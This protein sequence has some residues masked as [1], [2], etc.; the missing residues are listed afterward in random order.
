MVASPTVHSTLSPV[1]NNLDINQLKYRDVPIGT[2]S[3][4]PLEP[5]TEILFIDSR[6]EDYPNLVAYVTAEMEQTEV[7][8]LDPTLDCIE[9]ITQVLASRKDVLEVHIVLSSEEDSFKV[10]S[11][12]L[13]TGNEYSYSRLLQQLMEQSEYDYTQESV[14]AKDTSLWDAYYLCEN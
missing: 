12:Q 10:L 1:S 7:I 8:L 13:K 11:T 9:Q 5:L 14:I 6:V 3:S 2:K 4:T